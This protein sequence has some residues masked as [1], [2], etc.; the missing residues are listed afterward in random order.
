MKEPLLNVNKLILASTSPKGT[1]V[2]RVGH[3]PSCPVVVIINRWEKNRKI[4]LK[5]K[6]NAKCTETN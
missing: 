2:E 3:S 1:T 5:V 4:F 6:T